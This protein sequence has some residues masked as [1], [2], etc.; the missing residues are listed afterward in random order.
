MADLA[1]LLQR[2]EFADLV[3]GGELVVDAVEL[4]QVDGFHAET[5]QAHLAFLAQI[6]RIAQ[7]RPY[8]GPDAQES[9]LESR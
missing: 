3:L 1:F 7:N 9:S 5:A 4:E 6:R 8:V 2:D